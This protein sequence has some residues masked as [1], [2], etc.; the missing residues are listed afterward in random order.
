M[1][2]KKLIVKIPSRVHS[3]FK[4]LAADMDLS[5]AQLTRKLIAKALLDDAMMTVRTI[6][7]VGQLSPDVGSDEVRAF[8]STAEINDDAKNSG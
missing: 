2:D 6:K 8:I 4:N 5:M 1:Y 7:K 3:Q